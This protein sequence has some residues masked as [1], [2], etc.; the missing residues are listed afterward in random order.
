MRAN[1][2]ASPEKLNEM[3]G[4]IPVLVS[5][6]YRLAPPQESVL[7]VSHPP[8]GASVQLPALAALPF[9]KMVI[10]PVA[11]P[12]LEKTTTSCIFSLCEYK[13]G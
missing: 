11:S 1:S 9:N 10:L 7:Y 8:V 3:S 4:I 12:P 2:A 13:R 6:E 5:A